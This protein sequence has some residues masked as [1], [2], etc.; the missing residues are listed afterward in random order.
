VFHFYNIS[1][2]KILF[3]GFNPAM[4]H[5]TGQ[6]IFATE[7]S[8]EAAEFVKGKN[9]NLIVVPVNEL[10]PQYNKFDAVVAFDEYFT[11]A[12]TDI[13]QQ[14]KVKLFSSLANDLVI[15]TLKD[16]KNQDYKDREFSHPALVRNGNAKSILLESHD[17]D[18]KDKAS[19]TTTVYQIEQET[20]T[21]NSFGPVSRRTMYFKQLAKFSLDAGATNFLVHKNLM[22]KGLTKK[23]Y[24]HVISITFNG[25]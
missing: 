7:I 15:S 6:Q 16:Y 1:P 21:L 13:E 17:W 23:N 25:L 24:E 4:L 3:V 19:W 9:V 11:F 10:S 14:D 5:Y 2:Q 12:K 20:N 22:Y 8:N 18:L